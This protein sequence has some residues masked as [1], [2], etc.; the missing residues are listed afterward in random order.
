MQERVA[1]PY[2][3]DLQAVK[4]WHVP[5]LAGAGALR[6][7]VDD[8][9]KFVSAEL[10]LTKTSLAAAMQETQQ[11][12]DKTDEE[13]MEIGLGW[14]IMKR[15]D[16]PVY[17]HNGGTGGFRSFV[18]FCPAKKTGVVV[19]SNSA[20]GV[21]D[22]GFH[23]LDERFELKPPLKERTTIKI[24]PEVADRYLGKYE[25]VPQFALTFTREGNRY[26]VT[27]TG[28]DKDEVFPETK[29]QFFSKSFDGQIE[30]VQDAQGKYS[31]LILH[32]GGLP[33]QGAKR[34]P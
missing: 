23:L 5:A 3:R 13:V 22:I 19:L 31:S 33:D 21:D 10:G 30:F 26:F 12:R 29:T 6:S 27:A 11:V 17:W 8:M 16:P 25:V 18:G 32:Q 24:E 4:P 15:Y 20:F 1:T 14:L 2:G 7:D 9:L 34:L 28:Q